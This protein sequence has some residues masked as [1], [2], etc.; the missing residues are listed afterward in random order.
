MKKTWIIIAAI[1][2]AINVIVG[3]LL[4]LNK[5][6]CPC[7]EKAK[8][9]VQNCPCIEKTKDFFSGKFVCKVNEDPEA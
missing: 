3:V 4:I 7:M 8:N 1:I 9:F 6:N 5:R 2:V